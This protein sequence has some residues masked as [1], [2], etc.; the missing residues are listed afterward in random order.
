MPTIRGLLI[1]AGYRA[2]QKGIALLNR[3]ATDLCNAAVLLEGRCS[4]EVQ[5]S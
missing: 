5:V 4:I 1:F 3:L 2:L